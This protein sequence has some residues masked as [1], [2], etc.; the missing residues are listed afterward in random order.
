MEISGT[1]SPLFVPVAKSSEQ[2]LQSLMPGQL[3]Q[4][5]VLSE[6]RDGF[7]RVQIGVAKLVAETR[8]TPSPGQ[9]LTLQV[10][11][12]DG[13]LPQ[14]QLLL[15][16]S[17]AQLRTESLKNL[18]PKQQPLPQVLSR[19]D[20]LAQPRNPASLPEPIRQAATT[21][22]TTV[23]RIEQPDFRQVI[24]QALISS[25]LL[26]E[27]NLLRQIPQQ[28][29]LK[30][31]L[32]KLLGLLQQPMSANATGL[33]KTTVAKPNPTPLTPEVDTKLIADLIRQVEGGIARI[34][35]HQLASINQEDPAQ[36]LWQFELPIRQGEKIDSWHI[37]LEKEPKSPDS[38]DGQ[39]WNIVLRIDLEP[40]GPM[41]VNLKLRDDNISSIFWVE[42]ETTK[43]SL[44]QNLPRLSRA[45]A[46]AGL[47]VDK[48]EAHLG[49]TETP[50]FTHT[51]NRLL[52]EQ[53]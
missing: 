39:G 8:L 12:T 34:Q 43:T 36:P 20:Q 31:N 26:T 27:R 4:A 30:L 17:D 44:E 5:K 2:L 47:K 10:Q 3:L 15:P 25:G 49:K 35:L 14:L 38:P 37:Q 32:L 22:S 7:I 9:T 46:N 45:F 21:L 18:L 53:A 13:K 29:D 51:D 1:L 48:L 50:D 33:V 11:K 41:R 19:I 42:K 16:T 28:S 52:D 23:V 24:S 6:N 40:L